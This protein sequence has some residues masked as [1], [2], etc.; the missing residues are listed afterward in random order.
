[1]LQRHSMTSKS[2]GA[3]HRFP[4]SKLHNSIYRRRRTHHRCVLRDSRRQEQQRQ[5]FEDES[6]DEERCRWGCVALRCSE[7]A[8]T[9]FRFV[10]CHL[11]STSILREL[12]FRV[13]VACLHH[14]TTHI[15]AYVIVY[16]KIW[17]ISSMMDEC[18]SIRVFRRVNSVLVHF[19]RFP[20]LSEFFSLILCANNGEN[21]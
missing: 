9:R 11:A 12:C 10:K 4:P 21:A 8:V 17:L 19:F 1:M 16:A 7:C 20:C 3:I 13:C 5:G 14:H 6:V 15:K 2:S 18:L